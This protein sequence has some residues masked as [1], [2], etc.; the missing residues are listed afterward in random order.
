M[1]LSTIVQN[2]HIHSGSTGD[3]PVVMATKTLAAVLDATPMDSDSVVTNCNIIKSECDIDLAYRCLAGKN[4]TYPT[5]LR[6]LA[7]TDLTEQR[8]LILEALCSLCNGQPDLLDQS[9]RSS[10]LSILSVPEL[11]LL[12]VRFI[13]YTCIKHETNRRA[14][15][16]R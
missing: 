15:V 13:R 12:A 2:Q 7:H 9:G 5:L 1:D 6:A 16:G 10:I 3:H 11:T 14:Y 4:E 8:V